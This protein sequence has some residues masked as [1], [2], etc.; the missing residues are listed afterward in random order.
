MTENHSPTPS[1]VTSANSKNTGSKTHCWWVSCRSKA[2]FPT[3]QRRPEQKVY[4][5]CYGTGE[6]HYEPGKVDLLIKFALPTMLLDDLL[7]P[8]A[9]NV[10]GTSAA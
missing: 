2:S 10:Q 8:L 7:S 9:K 1:E 3:A 4:D 6:K 5:P